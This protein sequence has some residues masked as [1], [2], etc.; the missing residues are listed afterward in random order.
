MKLKHLIV[1]L[2]LTMTLWGCGPEDMMDEQA[3][4]GAG[5]EVPTQSAGSDE[6]GS[7]EQE[8][9][10][11]GTYVWTAGEAAKPMGSSSNRVCFL[12]R[13]RGRFNGSGDAVHAYISNGSWYLGGSGDTQAI[14]RC[15]AGTPSREYG[16][17]AGQSLPTYLGSNSGRVC[18]LTGVAGSFDGSGDW[19]RSYD[20]GGSWFLFGASQKGDSSAKARCMAVSSYTGLYSW[21][22]GA[23]AQIMRPTSS[24]VCAL[25]YMGGQFEGMGEYIDISPTGGYWYLGGA[26]QQW[27]VHGKSRCF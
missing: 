7:V 8:A 2:P 27:G 6:T 20:E 24:H 16:W 21:S 14:A 17:V 3:G 23:L 19:T 26:S 18:F 5:Q 11:L 12:T 25:M 10:S 13:I 15:V 9:T 1:A 4:A 22:Q